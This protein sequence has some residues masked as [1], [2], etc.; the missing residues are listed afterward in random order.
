MKLTLLLAS[1]LL[2]AGCAQHSNSAVCVVAPHGFILSASLKNVYIGNGA[3][4]LVEQTD[5]AC[6]K[7]TK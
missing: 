5:A 7:D 6:L 3:H 2:L 1:I 4:L